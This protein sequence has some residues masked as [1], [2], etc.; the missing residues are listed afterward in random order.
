MSLFKKFDVVLHVKIDILHD[1]N[2]FFFLV[3]LLVIVFSYVFMQKYR[4]NNEH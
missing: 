4:I 3:D 2:G 1:K